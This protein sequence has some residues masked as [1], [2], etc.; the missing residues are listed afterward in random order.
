MPVPDPPGAL[1][2][3]V[4]HEIA[5]CTGAHVRSSTGMDVFLAS[6]ILYEYL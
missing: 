3:F 1:F 6:G 2:S 4:V 5:E